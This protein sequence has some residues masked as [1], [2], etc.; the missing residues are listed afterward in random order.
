MQEKSTTVTTK[1]KVGE[2][3]FKN[4]RSEFGLCVS[5]LA[6]TV[7][8]RTGKVACTGREGRLTFSK[9]YFLGDFAVGSGK[10]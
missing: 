9:H 10:Q 3:G 4:I 1:E 5:W 2:K 6:T 8:S 7:P